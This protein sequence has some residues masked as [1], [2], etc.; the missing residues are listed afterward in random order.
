MEIG[1]KEI[2]D[3][4][5]VFIIAEIGINHNGKLETAKKL[6]DVAKQSGSDC[7]KFQTFVAEEEIS[8]NAPLAEYQKGE[9]S[10]Q[11]EMVKKLELTKEEFKNLKNYAENLKIEFLSTP[12]D[13]LSVDVLEEINVVGYKISSGDLNNIKL[14]KKIALTK[15]PI[16][17]STGM[18]NIDEIQEATQLLKNQ[19]ADYS[20]LHC[21]SSYPTKIEDCNLLAISSLKEKFGVLV[22]FSDH[23][24]GNEAALLAVALGAK[25]IEKHIT[26]DKTMSGPDHSMSMN[27][28]EFQKFV[29]DIRKAEI[30]LGNGI[31]RCLPCEEEIKKVARKS[32]VSSRSMN[33]GE[34]INEFDLKLKRP[35]TGIEPK[36]LD[37]VIGKC[38]KKNIEEDHLMKWDELD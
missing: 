2:S 18:A 19:G 15:K 38:L 25:I 14:L 7:V 23:T 37:K 10:N 24:I 34:I 29:S 31:K 5:P 11:L 12:F 21:V 16:I 13:E 30:S 36:Y 1:N 17:L 8:K 6:I 4:A 27:P 33:K 35:G 26:L 9:F 20:L 32:I 28:N 22:G 3:T